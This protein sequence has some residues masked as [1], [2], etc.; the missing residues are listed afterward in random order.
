[1]ERQNGKL[2]FKLIIQS[3]APLFALILIKYFDCHVIT[4]AELFFRKLF[5]GDIGVFLRVWLNECFGVFFV[6]ILSV[7]WIISAMIALWQF[8]DVQM[9]GFTDAGDKVA[10]EEELTESGIIFFMT[11]VFPLLLDDLTTLRGFLLF[12]GI[13]ALIFLLM[14]KTNLYY[15]N[16]ILTILGYKVYRIHFLQ[17]SG[18]DPGKKYIAICKKKLDVNKIVKWKIV[19]DDVLLIYNKNAQE[20][21]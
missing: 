16:P 9:S 12:S 4:S 6:S 7:G 21:S 10:I 11:F 1:M 19:S 5:H 8:R 13:L 20:V 14:W 2:K 18:R 17:E 15:Q 3:F